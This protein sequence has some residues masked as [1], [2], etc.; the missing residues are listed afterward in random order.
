V[1][2]V[3]QRQ[4]RDETFCPRA[5]AV[6]AAR[7]HTRLAKKEKVI[8]VVSAVLALNAHDLVISLD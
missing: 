7:A 5:G 6:N 8:M 3:L 1:E 4:R 2:Q